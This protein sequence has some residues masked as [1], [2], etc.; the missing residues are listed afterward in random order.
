MAIRIGV[1]PYIENHRLAYAT[2]DSTIADGWTD[3]AS[4]LT[5]S[6]T[7][8]KRGFG[9][10]KLLA[11]GA[12]TT[13]TSQIIAY[14]T[15]AVGTPANTRYGL[16][17]VAESDEAGAIAYCQVTS[18]PSATDLFTT[19]TVTLTDAN[20]LYEIY[21]AGTA[22]VGDDTDTHYIIKLGAYTLSN[23]KSIYFSRF[24]TLRHTFDSDVDYKEMSVNPQVEGSVVGSFG[25]AQYS[26]DSAGRGSFQDGTPGYRKIRRVLPFKHIPQADHE[27]LEQ[28]YYHTRSTP[29]ADSNRMLVVHDTSLPAITD[30]ILLTAHINPNYYAWTD[31]EYPFS[32]GS[33]TWQPSDEKFQGVMNLEEP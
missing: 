14:R 24:I 7:Y 27:W 13:S 21:R 25:F 29:A 3:S 32:Q 11:T 17:F 2:T 9:R 31:P 28:F 22:N 5:P 33:N 12:I 15:D 26:R 6:H 23:T 30:G 8:D 20:T 18:M 10:Q 1:G 16:N 4:L 19:T